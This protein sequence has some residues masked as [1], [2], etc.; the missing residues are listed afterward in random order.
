MDVRIF[1]MG[2]G[3]STSNLMRRRR[4]FFRHIEHVEMRSGKCS[5]LSAAAIDE[6]A[7]FRL[8]IRSKLRT[9]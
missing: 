6:H 9:K 2:R 7:V 1:S 5:A 3:A 8:S 4:P